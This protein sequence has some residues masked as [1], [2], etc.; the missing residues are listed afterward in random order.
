M[1]NCVEICNNRPNS[2]K[3]LSINRLNE[4]VEYPSSSLYS[5]NFNYEKSTN[6][7]SNSLISNKLLNINNK[8]CTIGKNS[9]FKIDLIKCDKIDL[10]KSI[11][12][13]FISSSINDSITDNTNNKNDIKR[14]SFDEEKKNE[15]KKKYQFNGPIY[16]H[17]IQRAKN[18]NKMN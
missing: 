16:T 7:L 12:D 11:E 2:E 6:P 17:L 9:K 13:Q 8:S 5:P 18:R 10:D 14:F 3:F 4:N 1:G 15:N